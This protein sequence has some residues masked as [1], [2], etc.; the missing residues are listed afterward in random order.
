MF[1]SG[2]S[3]LFGAERFMGILAVEWPK[4]GFFHFFLHFV[5]LDLVLETMLN[6]H[7]IETGDSLYQYHVVVAVLLLLLL[8]VLLIA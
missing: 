6:A 2:E 7:R 8:L 3:Q 5:Y 1:T 4:H